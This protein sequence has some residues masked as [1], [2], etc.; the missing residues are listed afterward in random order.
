MNLL[1][2]FLSSP[3]VAAGWD[4]AAWN[5][6]LPQAR[7]ARLL[8][9]CLFLFE[10]H[11]MVDRVPGRILDQMHGA[12]AQTRYVQGQARRELRQVWRVL[13]ARGIRVMALK[14]VAYLHADL[15]PAAW[16]SLS[17]ID[18]MVGEGDIDTAEQAL[19]QAGWMPSDEFDD[20]DQHYYRDWMHEVPPLVHADRE[21]EVDLHHN[22]APPVSRIHIDANMLWAD[23]ERIVDGH[24]LA[25]WVLSPVDRLLHGCGEFIG[26][27]IGLRCGRDRVHRLTQRGLAAAPLAIVIGDTP[28]Q[29]RGQPRPFAPPAVKELPTGPC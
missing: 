5:R 19:L 26:E 14:G 27:G 7:N 23:A 9:R 2:R 28:P 24:G 3:T 21:I 29:D 16:R 6:F 15:P 8:G 18:V 13:D 20:Y 12:L 17:D 22:L 11:E 1:T 25:V 4:A 10:A